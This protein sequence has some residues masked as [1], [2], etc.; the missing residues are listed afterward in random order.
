MSTVCYDELDQMKLS[1]LSFIDGVQFQSVCVPSIRGLPLHTQTCSNWCNLSCNPRFRLC[2]RGMLSRV[3]WNFDLTLLC[4]DC[5]NQCDVTKFE[6]KMP[7]Y[8]PPM[9]CLMHIHVLL[10]AHLRSAH[11]L[12]ISAGRSVVVGSF[13]SGGTVVVCEESTIFTI[14]VG[15][16]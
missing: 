2:F 9:S 4:N 7:I 13:H 3:S 8:A 12:L 16:F 10:H 11:V 6:W 5:G 14:A 15:L 1:L